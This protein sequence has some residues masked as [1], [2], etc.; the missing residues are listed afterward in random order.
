MHFRIS[1]CLNIH[2]PSITV[3][4]ACSSSLNAFDQAFTAIRSGQCD[5]A[6][7]CGTN[8]LLH[9]FTTINFARL[10]VISKDGHCRPFD[11]DCSGYV[12]S[13]AICA[14]YLQKAQNAKRIYGK[15]IYSDT[16]CD[17]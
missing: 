5:N 10:G 4:T 16:N 9:P 8:L 11:E 12:R 15:V 13:E 3:D 6:L 14:V 17:G 2:G 7:V 1:Y